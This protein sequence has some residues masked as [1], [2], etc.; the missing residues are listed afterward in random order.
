MAVTND[1]PWLGFLTADI[2][3]A[4]A[5]DAPVC[6]APGR[7]GDADKTGPT[8]ILATCSTYLFYLPGR[9]VRLMEG[10]ALGWC[11][12]S[13]WSL[14]CCSV[15]CAALPPAPATRLGGN[16]SLSQKPTITA[17]LPCTSLPPASSCLIL[18]PSRPSARP[19]GCA[20]TASAV[21]V[22]PADGAGWCCRLPRGLPETPGAMLWVGGGGLQMMFSSQRFLST[23]QSQAVWYFFTVRSVY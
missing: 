11:A 21:P 22:C 9:P 7:E 6:L 23:L 19:G 8:T 17:F 10:S 16:S 2:R 13:H 14:P 5:P 4:Q 3:G 15:R 12:Q 18:P 20:I 1:I